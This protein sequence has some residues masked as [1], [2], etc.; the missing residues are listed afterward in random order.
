[1]LEYR[2]WCYSDNNI[3]DITDFLQ[4]HAKETSSAFYTISKTLPLIYYTP[5][6]TDIFLVITIFVESSKLQYAPFYLDYM[7]MSTPNTPNPF[8]QAA[9]A[10]IEQALPNRP[11]K[12]KNAGDGHAA[13]QVILM[14]GFLLAGGFFFLYSLDHIRDIYLDNKL[15]DNYV[16]LDDVEIFGECNRSKFINDCE[17]EIEYQDQLIEQKFEFFAKE[18]FSD[19]VEVIAQK[20]D[21][22][23]ISTDVAINNIKGRIYVTI[24]MIFLSLAIFGW[25]L[26]LAFDFPK[27]GRIKKIMNDPANQPWQFT[28]LEV[29]CSGGCMEFKSNVDGKEQAIIL[30]IEKLKP[31][32]IDHIEGNLY[33]VLAVRAKNTKTVLPLTRKL[34][35]IDLT[36]QEKT[37]LLAVI[38]NQ[39]NL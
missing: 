37:D 35:N 2:V 29:D 28:A 1:M 9:F 22:N 5:V 26:K 12:L 39:L 34:G 25:G 16:I 21:L 24:L 6:A 3:K 30:H 36:K 31:V 27:K 14:T 8:W 32:I 10:T 38:D 17:I 15:I 20:D 7:I 19:E 11:L 18:S 33:W 4:K 23:N 13:M